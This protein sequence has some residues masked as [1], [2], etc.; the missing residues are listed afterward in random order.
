MPGNALRRKASGY[1]HAKQFKR[2]RRTVERQRTILGV[3][4][5]EVQRKLDAD[6]AAVAAH[7][8]A[9][10][11]DSPEALSDFAMWLQRAERIRNLPRRSAGSARPPVHPSTP[12][13]GRLAIALPNANRSAASETSNSFKFTQE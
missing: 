12:S 9:N 10:E 1:A 3:A 4:M 2:L 11:S 7:A 8:L 6:R 5:H 13:S